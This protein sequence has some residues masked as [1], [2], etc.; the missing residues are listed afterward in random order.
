MTQHDRPL[1]EPLGPRGP[2]VLLTQHVEE[3]GAHDAHDGAGARHAEHEGGHQQDLQILERIPRDRYVGPH[4]RPL[5]VDRRQHDHEHGETEVRHRER[6]DR[7]DAADVI[8]RGVLAHR[9]DDADQHADHHRD[10]DRQQRQLERHREAPHELVPDR[11][12]RPVRVAEVATQH[13]AADPVRVL[14]VD[15]AVEP[16]VLPQRRQGRRIGVALD[17]ARGHVAGHESHHREHD[18]AHQEQGGDRE[19]DAVKDVALHRS[20][21]CRSTYRGGACPRR[22]RRGGG[23]P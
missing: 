4:G 6:Q 8:G 13:D 20:I 17:H 16:E 21:T 19:P 22:S 1:A 18:H 15:G 14:D 7:Q 9:R 23:S 3:R 12:A 10:D 2:D 5:E 11:L